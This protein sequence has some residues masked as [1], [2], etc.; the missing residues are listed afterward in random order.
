MYKDNQQGLTTIAEVY[1]GRRADIERVAAERSILTWENASESLKDAWTNV[2]YDMATKA[3]TWSELMTGFIRNVFQALMRL[4]AQQAAMDLMGTD[5][6]QGALKAGWN[7]FASWLSGGAGP[8]TG[9]TELPSQL[10]VQTAAYG[11]V[12]M[13]PALTAIAE[14][15][16]EVAIPLDRYERSMGGGGGGGIDVHIHNESRMPLEISRAEDYMNSD[17]RILDVTFRQSQESIK[18]RKGMRG[19]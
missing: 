19:R 4:A 17:Q 10:D 2:F 8:D 14:R 15:G 6:K 11:G 13:K 7:A 16:P 9:T 12:F 1:A 5:A 18:Y 3:Q